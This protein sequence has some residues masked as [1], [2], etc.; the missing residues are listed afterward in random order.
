ML[1]YKDD[2]ALTHGKFCEIPRF[3][4]KKVGS[5]RYKDVPYKRIYYLPLI[6]KLKRLYASMSSTPHM[7]WHYENKRIDSV[8]THPSHGETW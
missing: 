1:Y 7:R 2:S 3:K 5:G 8:M 4:P 6:H